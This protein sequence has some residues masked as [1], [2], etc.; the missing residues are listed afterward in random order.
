MLDS[1]VAEATL[2]DVLELEALD[3]DRDGR[4]YSARRVVALQGGEVLFNLSCSFVVPE[5]GPDH[6]VDPVPAAEPPD[7]L[8]ELVLPRL[9]SMEARLP[10]QPVSVGQWPTR[11]W[12]RAAV[13]LPDD[14]LTHACVL[15]YL[16]DISTGMS[17]L[18][19]ADSRTGTSLDHAVWFHRPIRLDDWVLI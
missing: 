4:S 5:E 19:G 2:I 1:A 14:A 12:A 17:A 7:G 15:T 11:F 18:P 3:R 6:P 16:S 8:P 9:Y 10:T 13:A